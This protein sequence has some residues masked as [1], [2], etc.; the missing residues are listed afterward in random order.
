MNKAGKV[1]VALLCV[2]FLVLP[3]YSQG[4]KEKTVD[5]EQYVYETKG[6]SGEA[7]TDYTQ[8][9]LSDADKATVRNG[10]YKIAILM[11]ES[12]DWVNAVIAGARAMSQEL[13]MQVVAV[14]DAGQ[15]PNKQRTDIETTLAL[16]PD[17]IVTLV[18]DPVSGSVALKQAVDKGVHVVLISNL[19]SNFVHGKDYAG[20][21]TD[22]LFQMGKSVA[23]MIGTYLNGKGE[24]A[25]MYHDANYYVTNQRDQAVEAVLRR[26]YPGI[27]IVAK[28]G[29]V[30][31]SDSETLASAILTQY[32]AVNAIYAPWD[33]L[34][35]GVVAAAR[36]A[37]K[38]NV[39]VFTIDLGANNVMDMAKGGN[40]KGVVADLP[41]VLGE[42][43]VKMGALSMLGKPTPAF[44]TVPAISI[45][46][47]NV[48]EAWK[49]SLN[50]DLP[51]E[52]IQALK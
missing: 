17:I 52:I 26:D 36:T 34:A 2:L 3:V 38:K 16:N 4:V 18:L 45:T 29:I 24:V 8:V 27:K 32:P 7:P 1:F 41:Y 30:N 49:Q 33:V 40:L 42:S 10:K 31:A 13:N 28:R 19:P 46:K 35:E 39:G 15:D 9:V 50:R 14:T 47:A 51:Q 25:L 22:D 11:H 21:V 44:V 43:L 37:G 23:D 20:I 12:S 6:P 5:T 48:A